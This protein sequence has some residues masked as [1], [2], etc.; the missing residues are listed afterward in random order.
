MEILCFLQETHSTE[1]REDTWIKEWGGHIIYS[2]GTSRSKGVAI[3][4]KK[5]F[6]DNV[7]DIVRDMNGRFVI[8][9]LEYG[10]KKYTLSIIYAPTQNYENEQ[11]EL[12]NNLQDKFV[13][14]QYENIIIGGDFN[15]V[16]NPANDKKGGNINLMKRKLF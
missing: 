2:H 3:M 14:Q 4:M 12:I 1:L 13:Q 5:H 7:K 8:I 6:Y 15:I 16:L 10:G 9:V 11:I